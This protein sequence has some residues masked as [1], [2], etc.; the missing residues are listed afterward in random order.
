MKDKEKQIKELH[1][2]LCKKGFDG[3][4]SRA[5]FIYNQGYRKLPEDSVVLSREEYDG[6]K[7]VVEMSGGH[8]LRLSVGKFGEMSKILEEEIRKETAEKIF[9]FIKHYFVDRTL[10]LNEF[11]FKLIAKQFGVEIKD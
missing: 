1:R 9:S 8:K 6:K 11:T 5:K 2:L 7:I 3:E 10:V 4:N